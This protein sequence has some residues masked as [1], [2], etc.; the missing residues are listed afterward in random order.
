MEDLKKNVATVAT[1]LLGTVATKLKKKEGKNVATVL[2][3]TVATKLKKG[4]KKLSAA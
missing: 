1:V 4:R 3:G 2:L